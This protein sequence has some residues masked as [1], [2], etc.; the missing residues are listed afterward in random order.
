M[1]SSQHKNQQDLPYKWAQ[2]LN[3]VT[4]TIPVP[5]GTKGKDLDV[6]IAKQKLKVGLKGQPPII[7]VRQ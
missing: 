5:K 3:D 7:D 1:D 4:V 6:V 2:T